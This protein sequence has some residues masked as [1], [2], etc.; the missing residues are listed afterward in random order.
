MIFLWILFFQLNIIQTSY[1]RYLS[2][3]NNINHLTYY[4]PLKWFYVASI[5]SISIYDYNLTLLQNISIQNSD[6]NDDDICQI[7]PC[8]C[9][10]NLTNNN[11]DSISDRNR[12]SKL[13]QSSLNLQNS[14][15]Q[16]NYN[17][18]LYLEK[19]TKIKNKP[20]L[21]DCWSLQQ[22]SCIVRNALNL[23]DIY[24]QPNKKNSAQKFLFNT[25]ST[26]PNH[27]FPF[28]FKLNKCNNTPIYLF[29]T[30]TLKKN[31]ILSNPREKSD[32]LTDLF[33]LQCLEQ[34][35]RRTIALRAFVYDDEIKKSQDYV[36]KTMVIP[37]NITVVKE[38][39]MKRQTENIESFINKTRSSSSNNT[40]SPV[41]SNISISQSSSTISDDHVTNTNNNNNNTLSSINLIREQGPFLNI[42]DYCPEQLSV[43]RSIYTDFF[44]RESSDKFRLFQ[45]IIYDKNDSSIYLF[46]NQQYVSKII[47][48]CEGQ[49]S[50]RHYV[51]L[52]INCGNEYN[53]IQKVKLIKYQNKQYLLTIASKSKTFHSLEP[54]I[55][56]HSAI[57]LYDLDQIRNAF[58]DNIIDLSK[59]NI[60]L[61]MAWLHG[62][63]VIVR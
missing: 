11:D 10:N 26:I 14:F 39:I 49:I 24:Y 30:S 60:S 19:N 48:L 6:V 9:L 38:S 35:Q 18:I 42:N 17:L 36:N 13:I 25:D 28:H 43:V 31:F 41:T 37:R 34:A 22:G 4:S 20:Y 32:D 21:I 29:L 45:D 5:N 23:S 47:R 40:K 2:L 52:E 27:I 55:N 51:E 59:G 7:N 3:I 58:I 53:L 56:S 63:S 57:C 33:Y 44:E 61:G 1:I 8:Q 54:S 50:F 15:D 16:N 62:E 46:T 12:R